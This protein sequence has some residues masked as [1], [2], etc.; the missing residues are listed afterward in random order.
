MDADSNTF[1]R[2]Y[3]NRQQFH[4]NSN[5]SYNFISIINATECSSDEAAVFLD[6][7]FSV[8]VLWKQTMRA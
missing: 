5:M 1:P 2:G 3:D 8:L 6:N 4:S 7:F